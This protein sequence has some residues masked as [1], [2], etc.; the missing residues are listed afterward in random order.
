MISERDGAVTFDVK[1]QPRA[2]RD[3]VIGM[4]D[5]VLRIALRAPPVDGEANEAL[6][7][8]LAS[9]LGVAKR[10]VQILHGHGGRQKTV[11]ITG[12]GRAAIGALG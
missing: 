6:V 7:A 8:F 5:E 4:R 10:A 2:S 9:K 3:A 1:V 12:V 11:R